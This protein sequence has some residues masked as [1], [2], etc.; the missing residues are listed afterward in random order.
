MY[1]FDEWLSTAPC[2]FIYVRDDGDIIRIDFIVS[3]L[4]E[5]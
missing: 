1:K 2:D 4:E 3:S 5:E